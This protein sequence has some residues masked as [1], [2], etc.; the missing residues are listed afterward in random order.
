MRYSL[1]LAA[2]ALLAA[3]PAFA[4]STPETAAPAGPS[5]APVTGSSTVGQ[6]GTPATPPAALRTRAHYHHIVHR[7]AYHRHHHRIAHHNRAST[8]SGGESPPQDD[9]TSP[10]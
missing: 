4:Q 2:A 6:P 9:T 5:I 7:V 8:E 10:H 3:A 1:S